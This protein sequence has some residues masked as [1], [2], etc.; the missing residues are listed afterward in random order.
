MYMYIVHSSGFQPTYH[1]ISA[2]IIS[3]VIF[4]PVYR[5]CT[6]SPYKQG[7]QFKSVFF[8]SAKEQDATTKLFDQLPGQETHDHVNT[9]QRQVHQ[10]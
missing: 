8:L 5:Y 2:K 3:M 6:L 9:D 1:S 7:L 10:T 4:E